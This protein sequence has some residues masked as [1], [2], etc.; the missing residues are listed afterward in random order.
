MLVEDL[1]HALA[2]EVEPAACLGEVLGTGVVLN[3]RLLAFGSPVAPLSLR[4]PGAD[5]IF[6]VVLL[7]TGPFGRVRMFGWK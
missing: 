4:P 3:D 5:S 2:A 6:I 7:S 1:A